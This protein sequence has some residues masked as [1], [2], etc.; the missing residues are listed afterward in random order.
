MDRNIAKKPASK[1]LGVTPGK[2]VLIGVLSV[3]LVGVL[4]LQFGISAPAPAVAT[5]PHRPVSAAPQAAPQAAS[6]TATPQTAVTHAAD[7]TQQTPSPPATT[8][9]SELAGNWQST[10]I[11][12]VVQHDPFALPASF[13]QRLK[14]GAVDKQAQETAKTV[15]AKAE[16][17]ARAE[18]L[19]EVKTQFEQLQKEG[20]QIVMQKHDKYVALVGD[21]T[22]HV[23]DVIEGFTVVAIDAEGVRVARDLK[24]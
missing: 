14:P 12:K 10:D 8:T 4:Y 1:K 13:P 9:K 7:T 24:Q 20:V 2:L 21:R 5:S 22:I 17:E 19:K 3:V 23:G 16:E 11:T 18:V 15:D 6:Q